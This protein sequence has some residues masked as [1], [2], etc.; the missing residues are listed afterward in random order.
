[1]TRPAR[2]RSAALRGPTPFRNWSGVEQERHRAMQRARDSLA[3]R[4]L[5]DDGLA[6]ADFDLPDARR[7]ASNGVVEADAL[8]MLGRARVVARRAPAAASS[9]PARR[10]PRPPAARSGPAR[11]CVCRTPVTR[12]RHAA[13]EQAPRIERAAAERASC[14]PHRDR[15]SPAPVTLPSPT[16]VTCG[17]ATPAGSSGCARIDEPGVELRP[18]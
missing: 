17:S 13:A 18:R 9:A 16:M 10:T 14:R 15:R 11:P 5:N 4:L 7:A 3:T 12:H 6:L 2:L 1:M 8:R